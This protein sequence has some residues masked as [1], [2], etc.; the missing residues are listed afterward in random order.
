M[1]YTVTFNPSLDYMVAVKELKLGYTNRSF[2]EEVLYAGGKGINVSLVLQNLGHSSVALGFTAG[3]VGEEIVRQL[4]SE[5]NIKSNFITLDE[6]NS[7]IN[8]KITNSDG[9]EINGQGPHIPP[10]KVEEFFQTLKTLKKEDVL[11]LAGAIPPTL[12][13]DSYREIMKTVTC[14]NIIVDATGELLKN[15]LVYK[16]F[17]IKPNVHELEEFFGVS[18]ENE[19]TIVTYAKELQKLGARNVM[20][21]RGGEGAVLVDETGGTYS[22]PCPKGKLINAV[23]SGDSMVAGFLAGYL[24]KQSFLYAFQKGVATGTGSAFS[25]RFASA[26][27][28]DALMNDVGSW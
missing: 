19:E 20:I 5:N 2:G 8:V 15:T 17:L 27:L 24:E 12:S 21:S 26:D 6:G 22:L 4:E 3:F 25:S 14:D 1:I 18:I 7:R 28:V 10:N 13:P 23:G 16:P 11:V 9:T